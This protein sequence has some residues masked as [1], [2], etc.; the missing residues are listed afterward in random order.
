VTNLEDVRDFLAQQRIAMVGVSRNPKD[1]SRLL[2]NDLSKRGYDM[3]PVNPAT[4][5]IDDRMCF[6]RVQDIHPAPE[7]VL[8]MTASSETAKVVQDCAVAGIKRMW[9]YRAGGQGAI[10]QEAVAFCHENGIRLVEGHCPYMFL[11]KA[12]F[13]HRLHGF[14]LK[15][16]G[17][18]PAREQKTT[19]A[20]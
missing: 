9:M 6:S 13:V 5:T 1:F 12:G 8:V 4:K 2:F 3:V 11:S 17:S 10:N 19:K 20:A 14:V 18:Y 7:A 15:V 16:V